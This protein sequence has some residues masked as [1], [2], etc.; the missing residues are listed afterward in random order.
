MA[1]E[2]GQMYHETKLLHLP[3]D[4][5]IKETF[6][7]V[8]HLV[9]VFNCIVGETKFEAFNCCAIDSDVL[10]GRFGVL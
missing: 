3:I 6:R 5:L 10:G 1:S 8:L 4:V 7:V 2:I 9:Q